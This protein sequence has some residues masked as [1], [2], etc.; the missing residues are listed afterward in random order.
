MNICH[1]ILTSSTQLQNRSFHVVERT[2]T[3]SKCQK[4]RNARA[5]RSKLL[6]FIVKHANLWGFCCRCRRGCLS[7][8]LLKVRT[9]GPCSTIIFPHSTNQINF[10]YSK[11]KKDDDLS[12]ISLSTLKPSCPFV[13]NN[14]SL[15]EKKKP[16]KRLYNSTNEKILKNGKK[17]K[18][19]IRTPLSFLCHKET[20]KT[21]K[22]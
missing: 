20:I 22:F 5:K 7:S 3:S 19:K 21:C 11:Y 6:F 8:L 1:H 18:K 17:K 15:C 13:R 9:A 14:N 10:S 12:L 16:E 4:M 2:R